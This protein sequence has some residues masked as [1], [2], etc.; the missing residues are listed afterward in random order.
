MRHGDEG[1]AGDAE[2]LEQDRVHV[3]K[4]V[5]VV[6]ARVPGLPDDLQDSKGKK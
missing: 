2:A 5:A 1:E 4:G 3:R 6:Q